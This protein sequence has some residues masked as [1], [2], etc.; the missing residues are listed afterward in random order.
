MKKTSKRATHILAVSIIVVFCVC[1]LAPI[2]SA[3]SSH[4]ISHYNA[5]IT[6]GNNGNV[7]VAF[8]ITG[9]GKMTEIGSTQIVIYE[10]G[11]SVRTYKSSTTTSMMGKDKVFHSGTVTYAG[12]K[13][14]TYR[15]NVIFKCGNSNGHDNRNIDTNSVTA[16]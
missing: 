11:K 8:N 10:N 12:V 16:K 9:T 5:N 1:I 3:R 14:R 4:Y 2:A 7:T 6:A 15:A 13:G